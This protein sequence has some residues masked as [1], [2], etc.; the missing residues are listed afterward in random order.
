MA[1][2]LRPAEQAK[3]EKQGEGEAFGS[4]IISTV[5][6]FLIKAYF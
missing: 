5:F 6:M 2:M 1:V 3:V 4:S